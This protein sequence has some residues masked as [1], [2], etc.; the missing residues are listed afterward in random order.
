MMLGCHI[1]NCHYAT[2][3]HRTARRMPVLEAPLKFTGI[4]PK[5]FLARWVSASEGGLFAEMV[6]EFTEKLRQLPP[7]DLGLEDLRFGDV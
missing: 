6:Q 5:R 4:E 2:G 3:N 7:L 1:G